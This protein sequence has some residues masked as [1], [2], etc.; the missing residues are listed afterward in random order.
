M[1]QLQENLNSVQ[2]NGQLRKTFDFMGHTI[3][4][5]ATYVPHKKMIGIEYYPIG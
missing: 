3:E 1:E 2:M 4:Y 5:E